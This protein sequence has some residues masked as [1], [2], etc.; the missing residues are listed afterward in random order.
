MFLAHTFSLL[1]RD[2]EYFESWLS[3][4]G[5]VI[6]FTRSVFTFIPGDSIAVEFSRFLDTR[7]N[8]TFRETVSPRRNMTEILAGRVTFLSE[9]TLLELACLE[10]LRALR[11]RGFWNRNATNFPAIFGDT[12]FPRFNADSVTDLESKPLIQRTRSR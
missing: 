11:S 4:R 9:F 1:F 12:T 3:Y 7:G 5:R 2:S 6:H 10:W 8:C